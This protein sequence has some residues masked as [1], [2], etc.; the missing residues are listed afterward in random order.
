M[1]GGID[2]IALLILTSG[3]FGS[4]ISIC[5]HVSNDR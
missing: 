5:L 1:S 4:I 2:Y 3:K